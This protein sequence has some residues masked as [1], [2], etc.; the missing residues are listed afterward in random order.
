VPLPVSVQI[1]T[2]NEE[3]N[4]AA[5]LEA[6]WAAD[7]HECVVIDGGSSDGTVE[8][9]RALG[10]RVLSPGRLGLGPSRQVGWTMTDC[11]YV[12]FVD[13]DDRLPANWL[14]QMLSELQEGGYASLQSCLGAVLTETWWSQGWDQYFSESIT[15]AADTVMVGRPAIFDRAS[16]LG[17]TDELPSLD[18]DTY[19]SK[20]FEVRGLRQ[21]VGSARA[22]RHVE[23]TWAANRRKWI[24]YGRGYRAF[25]GDH[26]D[27]RRALL[28]H[29]LVTIP[30]TRSIRPVLRG[31]LTQP[32][33]G[34]LMAGSILRGWWAR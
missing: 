31:H 12:A 7:P 14:R 17:F 13:A 16:L 4:I 32:A 27:R 11:P 20:W 3:G 9:A 6:V 18:E 29:M 19:L 10:A 5:C 21:G 22:L 28:K 25:V 15:P 2:L 1:C 23:Q 26:P 33:F 34:A 30:I 24:S 8:I